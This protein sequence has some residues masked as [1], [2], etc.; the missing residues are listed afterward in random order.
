MTPQPAASAPTRPEPQHRALTL[1]V[2]AVLALAMLLSL[3]GFQLALQ[4]PGG[5]GIE[6][7][8]GWTHP[9]AIQIAVNHWRGLGSPLPDGRP[10]ERWHIEAAYLLVDTW[11]FMPLYAVLTWLVALALRASLPENTRAPGLSPLGQ[12]MVAGYL[13]LVC[14]VLGLLLAVDALENLGGS[15]RVGVPPWV[16]LG[17]ALAGLAM[18]W[19]MWVAATH[20]EPAARRHA[21]WGLGAAFGAGA[22]LVGRAVIGDLDPS[23]GSADLLTWSAWAHGKKMVLTGAVAA[24][25][26]GGWLFWLYGADRAPDHLAPGQALHERAWRAA[27]RS[28]MGAVVWR[29]RYVMLVLA[30][31][32]ALTL[33]LDQCRDV[34]LA[35]ANGAQPSRDAK[36]AGLVAPGAYR[37]GMVAV[38]AL[39]VGLLVHSTWLWARLVCRVQSQS[40]VRQTAASLLADAKAAEHDQ[41]TEVHARVGRFARFWARALSLVPL[42]CIYALVAFAISDAVNAASALSADGQLGDD[43]RRTVMWLVAI[44]GCTVGLGAV[45]LM[46]RR[47]LTL[48]TDAQYFNSEAG[49]YLLLRGDDESQR[50]PLPAPGNT[51]FARL[52][53]ALWRFIRFVHFAT[54]LLKPRTVP[55][56]ALGLV[57]LIRYGLARHPETMSMVPAALALVTLMLVWWMGV[58]GAL[59][60]AEVRLGRPY[61]LFV[62][63]L[64]G[65]LAALPLGV[66]NNHVLA[67]QLPPGDTA[68]LAALRLQGLVLASV[69]AALVGLLWWL[70]TADLPFARWMRRFTRRVQRS[71][72]PL[73]QALAGWARAE[74]RFGIL[75]SVA[76]GVALVV[77]LGLALAALH[78]ADRAAPPSP[79]PNEALAWRPLP[80]QVGSLDPEVQAWIRQLPPQ[81][82]QG[83][84]LVASEGGG[85]RS[86]YW[87]AQVLA[88]LRAQ[89][90]EFD[91]RT[92]ALS[93]VSGG[94]VG[95]AAYS[96]CLRQLGPQGAALP[97]VNDTPVQACLRKGF[98]TLDPLSPLL[99]A[100][101]FEDALAR[102]LPVPMASGR[103]GEGWLH[104]RHPACGHLSRALSFEREWM[105]ALPALALPLSARPG[106]DGGWEP[107]LLLNSTWVESGELAPAASLVM[108]ATQFPA[109]RDVQRHLGRELSLIGGAHVAARFPFI[110]PLAAVQPAANAAHET[111]RSA[112]TVQDDGST[113]PVVGHLADGGY[114]DNSATV[115]LGPVWRSVQAALH[116]AKLAH[117][118]TIVVI[119]NGQ[120]PAGCDQPDP[121]GPE[122]KC[123]VPQRQALTD[124]SE[125][126]KPRRSRNWALYADMLGPL[127][128]VLNVSGTGAHG[129]FAPAD[130]QAQARA[131]VPAASRPEPATGLM[132]V[133]QLNKGALVPL[134]WYLS[135]TAR[136]ALD[137]DAGCLATALKAKGSAAQG[138]TA[139]PCR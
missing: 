109:A 103:D 102:V 48:K 90:G 66:G 61:G 135:P 23:G 71:N 62:V 36:E 16:F 130:L 118:V 32:A 75:Q 98:S 81:A 119:R 138:P 113:G 107:H 24:V 115:A 122:A 55:L 83:V 68:A 84:F 47:V 74:H 21:W 73:R 63:A 91:R 15:V 127:V 53:H 18:A 76:R 117:P 64:L 132:P 78:W 106:Q 14:G 95:I 124:A 29:T 80:R 26:A 129:R 59:T 54:P 20:R 104:C 110:N 120:K 12:A 65:L 86:A 2:V 27:L 139:A 97:M 3:N 37:A 60:L 77:A 105:R 38:I 35:L 44:G 58:A 108:P 46:M 99:G 111:L 30:M 28:R 11:L 136:R 121:K 131:A 6:D 8:L 70:F 94:A 92:F 40:D 17:C 88:T 69:L 79:A 114:F 41:W 19:A 85:I 82:S 49:L 4:L 72:V 9:D 7:V 116:A 126:A 137:I 123:I 10:P 22:A 96:A 87:T 34:L 13:P 42:V 112:A 101:L 128:T 125:L 93:G 134:G 43:L 57:M 25:L 45:F 56:I 31:F 52:R 33:G 50:P 39:A 5:Q 133:D 89:H 1:P 67:L 51:G 100:W